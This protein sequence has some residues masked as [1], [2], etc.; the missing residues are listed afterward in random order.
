M[1]AARQAVL[2]FLTVPVGNST[3]FESGN[4]YVNVMKVW[5]ADMTAAQALAAL[6]S[7][8]PPITD[9]RMRAE[10][11]DDLAGRFL[12][13]N[14]ED[15]DSTL[16]E[17][18]SEELARYAA[19][20]PPVAAGNNLYLEQARSYF[21]HARGLRRDTLEPNWQEFIKGFQPKSH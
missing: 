2:P 19:T 15:L 3:S 10:A 13:S 18:A 7:D 12:E 11:L 20:S 1:L 6:Y 9:Q 5:H 4:L 21:M 8:R 14:Y 17:R 16:G